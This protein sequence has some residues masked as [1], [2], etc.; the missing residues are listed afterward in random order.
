MCVLNSADNLHHHS[1]PSA[2]AADL[3][4]NIHE[5]S[6]SWLHIADSAHFHIS[7]IRTLALCRSPASVLIFSA[8]GRGQLC[9]WATDVI[10]GSPVIGRL[11]WLASHTHHVTWRRKSTNQQRP[12]SDIRY[13]KVTAF[14][15]NDLDPDFP[16][17]LFILAV[18]CSDGFVR[19]V[20]C[21]YFI[22][23]GRRLCDQC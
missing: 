19:L 4:M 6:S 23:R 22:L 14:S 7:S 13:M 17:D 3:T 10:T 5:Y 8:G 12:Q 15:A 1:P 18:A 21:Y 9:A 16:A 2:A 11:Q 20:I